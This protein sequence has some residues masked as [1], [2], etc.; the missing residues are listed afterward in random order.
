VERRP[1]IG[2]TRCVQDIP[3]RIPA[4][5]DHKQREPED[6]LCHDV[7]VE[8]GSK[9]AAAFVAAARERLT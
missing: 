7:R 6:L 5:P 9:L 1:I 4:A 8:L 2:V 3:S